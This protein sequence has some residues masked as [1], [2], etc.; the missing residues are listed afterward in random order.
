MWVHT[1]HVTLFFLQNTFLLCLSNQAAWLL[2]K[3]NLEGQVPHFKDQTL[4]PCCCSSGQPSAVCVCLFVC[5]KEIR[6]ERSQERLKVTFS[7]R[8]S[9]QLLTPISKQE[10]QIQFLVLT[11]GFLH[12]PLWVLNFFSLLNIFHMAEIEKMRAFIPVLLAHCT[13]WPLGYK[14]F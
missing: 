4:C 8:L 13:H 9:F 12:Y 5:E 1:Y 14:G 11:R 6:A 2:L 3:S 7:S 10:N